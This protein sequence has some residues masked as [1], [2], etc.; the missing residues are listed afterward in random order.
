MLGISKDTYTDLATNEKKEDVY[1][2][3]YVSMRKSGLAAKLQ[4][5]NFTVLMMIC[6]YMNEEGGCYPTQEQLAADC[7]ITKST[8][9]RAI[10][11]LL[12]FE[13][14]G[15]PIIS[16]E[17]IQGKSIFNEQV[18]NIETSTNNGTKVETTRFK[19]AKD[20]GN[21]FTAIY[22]DVYGDLPNINYKR[23]YSL[24]KK[25]W[26]GQYTD[27][28]IKTMI[29]VGIKEY[30]SRWKN[31]QYQRPSLAAL[32]SWIGEQALGLA[33]NNEK[34]FK[35]VSEMTSDYVAMNEK[36]LEKMKSRIKK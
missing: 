18:E 23:D 27:E 16:R 26:L 13:F 12:E 17:I 24:V 30:D 33:S 34:E 1:V 5:T 4:P 19:T 22:R 29:D 6:T 11:E 25:K 7:G 35:E 31:P 8:V 15:K 20:V 3:L 14:E 32:V 21:Y 2:R 36:V 28:Q 9:N 10:K